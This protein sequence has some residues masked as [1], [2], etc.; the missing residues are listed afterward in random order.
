MEFDPVGATTPVSDVAASCREGLSLRC[1]SRS[2]RRAAR[3]LGAERFR[4]ASAPVLAPGSPLGLLLSRALSS[5]QASIVCSAPKFVTQLLLNFVEPS[6]NGDALPPTCGR[7]RR[8]FPAPGRSACR[9]ASRSRARC[10]I[11]SCCSGPRRMRFGALPLPLN[12]PRRAGR[13]RVSGCRANVP[14]CHWI[15]GNTGSSAHALRQASNASRRAT[16]RSS[17]CIKSK[18]PIK[19]IV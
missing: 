16:S 1:Q 18:P 17:S 4:S 14:A 15:V 13:I 2:R 8:R 5:A 12:R 3:E 11:T 7:A 6:D 10:A 9:P 19:I